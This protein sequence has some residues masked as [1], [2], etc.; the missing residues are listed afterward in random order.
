MRIDGKHLG[1]LG[2]IALGVILLIVG[3]LTWLLQNQFSGVVQGLLAGGGIS[4]LVGVIL[5][6][7]L[8]TQ[9]VKT[10][11]AKFGTEAVV[12]TIGII[13]IV[14]LLNYVLAQPDFIW[15]YD[16]TADQ[17]NTLTA[18]TRALLQE[19]PEGIR[20]VAFYT[21]NLQAARERTQD[22]LARYAQNSNGNFDYIFYDP[23]LQPGRA[24]QY[25]ITRDG[26]VFVELGERREVVQFV[27]EDQLTAAI[28][29]LVNQQEINIY[30]TTGHQERDIADTSE[31]GISQWV[32]Q[33]TRLNYTVTPLNLVAD[34][35]PENADVVVIAGPL[36]P[37]FDAEVEKL[38]AYLETGGAV[39]YLSE[40]P[41]LSGLPADTVDPWDAYLAENWYVALNNDV[42]VDF[43]QAID[44]ALAPLAINYA[45]SVVTESVIGLYTWFFTARSMTLGTA[46][47]NFLVQPLVQSGPLAWG[48]T[49]FSNLPETFDPSFTEGA[50]LS[51]PLTMAALIEDR[52]TTARLVVVGDVDFITNTVAGDARF[53]NGDLGLNIV[54]WGTVSEDQIVIERDPPTERTFSLVTAQDNLIVVLLALCFPAVLIIGAGLATWWA[55]RE[56]PVAISASSGE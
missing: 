36:V 26:E 33:M 15:E 29:R 49:D 9:L 8:L 16:A 25:G 14:A 39:I 52:D 37:L 47:G 48:E 53:A 12:V 19:L 30:F 40:P 11:Q 41:A 55:R 13:A 5:A 3:L 44:S 21:T 22:L 56:R 6:I 46:P 4:I 24:Q 42:V 28:Y 18:E 7:D 27:T 54:K 23:Q 45:D 10:R 51:G 35:I 2:L 20:V 1:G 50:D 17:Q 32:A 43:N 34:D 31:F 38:A